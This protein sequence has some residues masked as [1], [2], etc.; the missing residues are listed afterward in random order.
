MVSKIPSVI[1]EKTLSSLRLSCAVVLIPSSPTFVYIMV[2]TLC[3]P[4]RCICGS[5]NNYYFH[6]RGIKLCLRQNP[7]HA[8]QI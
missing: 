7:T 8:P 4:K 1:S 6:L 3:N 2:P 5:E